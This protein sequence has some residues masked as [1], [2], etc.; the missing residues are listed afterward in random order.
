MQASTPSYTPSYTELSAQDVYQRIVTADRGRV[1][2]VTT[3]CLVIDG[4]VMFQVVDSKRLE[5]KNSQ[6][7]AGVV[8]GIIEAVTAVPDVS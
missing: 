2:V 5:M 4:R 3:Q 8:L 7:F 1:S 6:S